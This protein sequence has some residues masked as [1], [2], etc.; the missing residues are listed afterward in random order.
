MVDLSNLRTI[1]EVEFSDIVEFTIILDDKLRVILIDGSYIDFWWS[2]KL[3]SRFA[4]HWERRHVD[5]T[6][7]RHDNAP[8]AKWQHLST[9]PQHFHCNSDSSVFESDLSTN[10][11]SAVRGFLAFARELLSKSSNS[12]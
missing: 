1:A 9:F 6:I 3:I 4:H 10:P 7:Y 12:K 2:H 5:G 8:H 11:E